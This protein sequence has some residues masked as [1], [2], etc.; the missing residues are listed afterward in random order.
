MLAKITPDFAH[1]VHEKLRPAAETV[2]AKKRSTLFLS[3]IV[4]GAVFLVCGAVMYFMMAPYRQMPGEYNITHWPLM[5]I[6]PLAMAMIG[7]CVVYIIG[8][9]RIVGEFRTTLVSRMAEYIDP[10][11][12]FEGNRKLPAAALADSLLFPKGLTAKPGNDYFRGRIEDTP[13]ELGTVQATT[14]EKSAA[15][16]RNGV[17][18]LASLPKRFKEPLVIVPM[19]E[20]VS[21][22]ALEED[23]ERDGI[24]VADGLIRLE[25][26]ATASQILLPSG[27]KE[28]GARILSPD[29]LRRLLAA[30]KEKDVDFYLSCKGDRLA[31]ALLSPEKRLDFPNLFE[32][33]NFADCQEFCHD[34][35]LMIAVCREIVTRTDLFTTE[36]PATAVAVK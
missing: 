16:T 8:L 27:D 3:L 24:A 9:R 25:D 21:R 31:V 20:K 7:F 33:F 11:L 5:V 23:L 15:T 17:V 13:I 2:T 30:E 28:T 19:G 10:V 26:A 29:T 4:A 36:K 35:K 32:G 34:A 22:S 1:F 6:A 12:V 14:G 18:L